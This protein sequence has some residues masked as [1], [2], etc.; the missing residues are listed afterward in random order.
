MVDGFK[1]GLKLALLLGEY[2]GGMRRYGRR[3]KW[4]RKNKML[5]VSVS[6]LHWYIVACLRVVRPL[7]FSL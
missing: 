3:T 1:L 4:W 7:F 6:G 5:Y 2:E